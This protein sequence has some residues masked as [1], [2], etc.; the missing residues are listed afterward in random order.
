MSWQ[1]TGIRKDPFAEKNRVVDVV[2]KRGNERGKYLHPEVYGLAQDK[3]LYHRPSSPHSP[4]K[5]NLKG[6]LEKYQSNTNMDTQ[7]K[8]TSTQ[9]K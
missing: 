4:N 7:L 8:P 2:E 3:G 1:V 9:T 5:T 6:L